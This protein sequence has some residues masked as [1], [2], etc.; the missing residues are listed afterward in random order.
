MG[1]R[2]ATCYA[3]AWISITT[4]DPCSTKVW[5]NSCSLP[6]AICFCLRCCF[7][8]EGVR[9]DLQSR[10]RVASHASTSCRSCMIWHWVC[11]VQEPTI[12]RSV[13]IACLVL[14]AGRKSIHY[15]GLAFYCMFLWVIVY[16]RLLQPRLDRAAA[17][18]ID[19]TV[20]T[21]DANRNRPRPQPGCHFYGSFYQSG[22]ENGAN[23]WKPGM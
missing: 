23:C 16:Y 21:L 5:N 2:C 7:V 17:K 20:K 14:N 10:Q 3:A 12:S 6:A 8:W 15:G 22:S 18:S 4:Q 19:R 9:A 11:L 1:W 13:A